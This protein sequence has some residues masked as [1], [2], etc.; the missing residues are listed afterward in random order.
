MGTF[1]DGDSIYE[2]NLPKTGVIVLGN[3]ANGISEEVEALMQTRLSIP[4][5]GR[6]NKQKALMLQMRLL[7]F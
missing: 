5:F 6:L 7:L 1:M 4:R 2:Q 3:E